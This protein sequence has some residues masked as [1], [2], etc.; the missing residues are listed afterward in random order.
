[1]K[2]LQFARQ[3]Q[4]QC[5]VSMLGDAIDGGEWDGGGGGGL[6]GRLSVQTMTHGGDE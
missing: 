2:G 6:N 4:Q 3:E 5:Q 1:M